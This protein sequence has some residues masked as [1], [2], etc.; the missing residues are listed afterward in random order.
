MV[1]YRGCSTYDSSAKS[2]CCLFTYFFLESVG[3]EDIQII[4]FIFYSL[5]SLQ[6]LEVDL[7]YVIIFIMA[8]LLKFEGLD[9]GRC[10]VSSLGEIY[11]ILSA[12]VFY[13]SIRKTVGCVNIVSSLWF[14]RCFTLCVH[15]QLDLILDSFFAYLLL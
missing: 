7:L 10:E 8:L 12:P 14:S 1:S 15:L 6:I 2:Y 11:G 4:P 9:I 3:L 5:V 13:V